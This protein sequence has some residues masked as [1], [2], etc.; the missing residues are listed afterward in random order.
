MSLKL[1]LTLNSYRLVREPCELTELLAIGYFHCYLK[2]NLNRKTQYRH[3]FINLPLPS[4][5]M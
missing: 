1:S 2:K 4:L 5:L 3:Y